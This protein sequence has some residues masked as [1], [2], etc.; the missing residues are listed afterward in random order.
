MHRSL[1]FLP[2]SH[3]F[4]LAADH[5]LVGYYAE[6][7]YLVTFYQDTIKFMIDSR[8]DIAT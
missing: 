8:E 1:V 5:L 6:R 7:V 4:A 3:V 2:L